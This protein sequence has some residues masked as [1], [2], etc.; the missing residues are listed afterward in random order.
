MMTGKVKS[1]RQFSS[2]AELVAFFETHNIGEYWDQMPEAPFDIN[3]KKRTHFFSRDEDLAE[4]LAQIA[5]ARQI[6][7]RSLIYEGERKMLQSR[8]RPPLKC[9]PRRRSD[10]K[11]LKGISLLFQYSNHPL[12][13]P[14]TTLILIYFIRSSCRA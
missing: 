9:A 4:T 11:L 3:V 5:R 8:H 1:I 14:S 12:L 10:T 6:R 2:L 13:Q 7:L